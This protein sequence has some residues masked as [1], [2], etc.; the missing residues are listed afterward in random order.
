[1]AWF[2]AQRILDDR[3]LIHAAISASRRARRCRARYDRL[4]NLRGESSE[5]RRLCLPGTSGQFRLDSCE[6]LF[7][8]LPRVSR[9]SGTPGFSPK[10]D[11]DRLEKRR[12]RSG[13]VSLRG[14]GSLLT[15][16]TTTAPLRDPPRTAGGR[17]AFRTEPRQETRMSVRLIG[18]LARRHV[19]ETCTRPCQRR[20]RS[21]RP[22]PDRELRET[23]V[24]DLG[25]GRL[26]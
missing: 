11:N 15:M 2:L 9:T 10:P 23:E 5:S 1:M 4:T 17:R 19:R 26:D 14:F 3:L 20:P 25:D 16:E 22:W 24:D 18:L 7:E 12:Q 8:Q 6:G 13:E 21:C